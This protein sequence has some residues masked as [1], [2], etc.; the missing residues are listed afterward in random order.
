MDVELLSRIQFATT[1]AFH[2]LFPPISI[3]FALFIVFVEFMWLKTGDEKYKRAT[4]F[5][6]KL[7]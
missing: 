3:G 1:A 2:F 7:F 4:K 6:L 5:F